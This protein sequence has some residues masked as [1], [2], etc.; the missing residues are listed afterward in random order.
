MKSNL[1]YG[2]V[3][4]FLLGIFLATGVQAATLSLSP[5]LGSQAVG[6]TFSVNIL[7]DTQ[8]APIDGGDDFADIGAGPASVN[9]VSF[10]VYPKTTTEYFIN[11]TGTTDYIWA[12]CRNDHSHRNY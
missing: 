2:R 6:S 4:F 8:G 10:W 7:L 5:S 3:L 12:R 9:T 1:P 11:L